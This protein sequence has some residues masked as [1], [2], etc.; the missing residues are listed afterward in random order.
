MQH[1]LIQR[2][3]LIMRL[4][5]F[6]GVR[7]AHV[8]PSLADSVVPIIIMGDVRDEDRTAVVD[9]GCVGQSQYAAGVGLFSTFQFQNPAGSGIYA[10]VERIVL[11]DI[12]QFTEWVVLQQRFINPIFGNLNSTTG[13]RDSWIGIPG[14]SG[15]APY[16]V[17][18]CFIGA[19]EVGDASALAM[20][21]RSSLFNAELSMDD[22][23][24]I[25]PGNSLLIQNNVAARNSRLAIYWHETGTQISSAEAF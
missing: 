14:A 19:S 16:S 2:P 13:V 3:D 21:R 11:R 24:V 4:Q 10:R 8:T 6:L 23:W 1:N 5:K 9:V 7:Q 12:Q 17:P 18:K 15:S 20:V 22:E 25:R